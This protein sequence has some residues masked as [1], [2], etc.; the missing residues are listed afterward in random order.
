[1]DAQGQGMC[2]EEQGLHG[3]GPLGIT[4]QKTQLWILHPFQKE[5]KII[6]KSPQKLYN[7]L[8]GWTLSQQALGEDSYHT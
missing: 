5:G 2:P 7:C 8:M 3:M 6:D 1:M 4:S